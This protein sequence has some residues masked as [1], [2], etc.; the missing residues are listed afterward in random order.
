M[1]P[2]NVPARLSGVAGKVRR[3]PALNTTLMSLLVIADSVIQT[4][5]TVLVQ[6]DVQESLQIMLEGSY[7]SGNLN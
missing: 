7:K 4:N 3:L 5:A 6:I 1:P 2:R